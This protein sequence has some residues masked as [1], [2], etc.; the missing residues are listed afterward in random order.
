[1]CVCVAVPRLSDWRVR[2]REGKRLIQG[3]IDL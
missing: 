3:L 1:M 2:Q